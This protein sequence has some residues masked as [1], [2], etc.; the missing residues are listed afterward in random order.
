MI[1]KKQLRTQWVQNQN[2]APKNVV[3]TNRR[4]VCQFGTLV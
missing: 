3:V 1:V 2:P 4:I